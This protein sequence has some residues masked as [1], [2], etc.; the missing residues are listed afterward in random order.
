ML[1]TGTFLSGL[2]HVGLSTTRPGRAGDP[3]AKTLG[4]AAARARLPGRAPEDRH[5]AA[6]RRPHDRLRRARG[7][8]RRRPGA[9]VPFL[10]DA[11]DASAAAALL[12][13]AH[14]RAHAR[15]HPRRPRPLAAVHR[16]HQGRRAALLPVDRGQGR[17]LRRPRRAT[18]SSSSRRG[19][20][21]HEIYPNGI[22]TSLPFDVQLALVRSIP[23][24]EQR[25]HH[26]AGLRDRVRLLRSA[27]AAA[28]ARD[29]GDPRA[30]PRRPD[31]R[32]DR[33]RGG[34]GAGPPRRHQRGALRAR[35]G[36]AGPAP[37]RGLHR[38]AGR[39]SRHARR[40]P[41]RTACSRRAPSTGCC[42]ARTTPICASRDRA[43][44][45]PRRRRALGRVRAQAR[46]DRARA[47][48]S[49]VDDRESATSSRRTSRSR[50]RRSRSSANMRSPSCCAGPA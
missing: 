34:G 46:R 24:F 9:G 11:R 13:H 42:C 35:R 50:P 48:A 30:L 10:G 41:S 23:G 47:G 26:A 45:R 5:A 44:A 14:E 3:P 40:R 1:T 49:Q 6:P 7:A 16:R 19:S 29:Q 15:D 36:R 20:T 43:R 22:S 27:R 28:D 2:I 38:R 21:T 32:H 17:A 4:R 25:A 39:R 37:R 33:L 31:Q 18:R 8:A 12:D